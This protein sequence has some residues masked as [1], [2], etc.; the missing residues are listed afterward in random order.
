MAGRALVIQDKAGTDTVQGNKRHLYGDNKDDT[1]LYKAPP[2][3][4]D[5]VID[6]G[7]IFLDLDP[8]LGVGTQRPLKPLR[9]EANFLD[10]DVP[11]FHTEPEG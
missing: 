4:N 7:D 11:L 2:S 1:G 8:Q 5:R 10:D 6:G 3:V 9:H